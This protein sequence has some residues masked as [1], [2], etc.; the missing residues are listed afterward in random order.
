MTVA[1]HLGEEEIPWVD[2]GTGV[3]LKL[4]Q[5]DIE[6]GLWIVRNRF[7]PGVVVQ[8]HKHTGQVYGYTL[9]GAWMYAEYDYVNRAGSFL[10]EPAGSEHTLTVLDDNTELTDVWFQIYGSNLNLDAEG[11]VESITD[12]EGIYAA[13]MAMCEAQGLG[14]PNVLT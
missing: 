7:A 5:A 10:Y 9:T 3:E 13:Y 12:A 6:A 4:V 1:F 11:N 2:T 14:R 8:K